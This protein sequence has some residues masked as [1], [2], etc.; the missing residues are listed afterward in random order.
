[1]NW[2][3][4]VIDYCERLDGRFWAE[5]L[6]A[7]SNAAFLVAAAAAYSLLRRRGQG[8]A[9]AAALI[10]VTAAVGCGSFIFHTVATR[11]AML[12]D[13]IPIAV[14][15]YGYFLLA[16]TRFF[17]MALLPAAAVTLGFA[18]ASFLVDAHIA[19]LNGSV[20]YLPALAALVCFSALLRDRRP[21]TAKGLA[22]AA[23]TFLVSLTFRTIDRD[24]C[25][26]VPSGAHF[27]W[28]LLNACVLWLL[29]RTAILAKA[30]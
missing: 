2:Q 11:G 18:G 26:F 25:A 17:G 29:L 7:F 19:G 12:L 4:P 23:A 5:P 21:E 9:P 6:N 20:A 1:M 16:L 10:V 13:V 28:H 27:L 3:E 15:I 8:D 24:I 22:A 14:F 30:D